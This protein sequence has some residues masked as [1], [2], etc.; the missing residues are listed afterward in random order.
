M[1][2]VL[3][4][5]ARFG[6]PARPAADG[7]KAPARNPLAGYLRL[8]REP[9][10][11]LS[12]GLLATLTATF[13]SFLAGLPLVLAAYGVTPATLGWY[14]AVVPLAYIA[15]NYLT[16]R[17]A[18]THSD[19]FIM[20]WGQ[21]ATVAGLLLVLLLAL[22][23]VR[24][25][26]AVVLPLLLLGIGHGLVVPPTLAG[27]VGVVPALAGS[28]AAVGGVSQQVLGAVGAFVVGLLPHQGAVNL[29]VLMLAWTLVGLGLQVALHAQR[30]K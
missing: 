8:A 5:A 28:A 2:A 10:F 12:V 15:G 7:A 30:C 23:G 14:I 1:G 20:G 3:L 6:L 11:W 16:T 25:P 21:V 9:T 24:S 26:V 4:L 18:R 13:Y 17:L 22:A 27:T 19:R 29:A